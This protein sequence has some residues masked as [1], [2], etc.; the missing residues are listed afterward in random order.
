MGGIFLRKYWGLVTAGACA[1]L[2]AGVFGAGGGLVLVP[3]LGVLTDFEGQQVFAVS[4]SI[5]LPVCLV[6]IA[7]TA[8]TAGIDFTSSLPYLPGSALGGLAAGIWG[9]KIPD[10]WLHRVLGVLILWGGIRYLC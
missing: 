3:L 5:I 6:S 9:K 7:V 2:V 4:L 8:M 1:G 10:V